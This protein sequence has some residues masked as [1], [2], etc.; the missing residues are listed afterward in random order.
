MICQKCGLQEATVHLESLVFRQKVE[1][2]L[3][4]LCAGARTPE[5]TRIRVIK[6]VELSV[7]IE[8]SDYLKK[9]REAEEFLNHGFNVSLCLKFQ[10]REMAHTEIGFEVI[11]RAAADLART[12][13]L[14]AG[15]KLIGRNIYIM[16]TPLPRPP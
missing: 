2:N 11:K 9:L 1:E 13:H 10:G 12:G 16:L 5:G 3:C 14:T 15:P 6:E 4:A 7:R 8:L